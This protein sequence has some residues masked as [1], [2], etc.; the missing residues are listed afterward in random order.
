MRGSLPAQRAVTDKNRTRVLKKLERAV[1]ESGIASRR[2]VARG[3]LE[4]CNL[5]LNRAQARLVFCR[6]WSKIGIRVLM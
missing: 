5:K 1:E 6:I 4:E 2:K 3:A